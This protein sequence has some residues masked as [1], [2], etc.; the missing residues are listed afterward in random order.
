M[1]AIFLALTLT[2]VAGVAAA[3]TFQGKDT[4]GSQTSACDQ[5]VAKAKSNALQALNDMDIRT[6]DAR[7]AF[8]SPHCD[9]E[10]THHTIPGTFEG[11]QCLA[12]IEA[13]KV[14]K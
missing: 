2:G 9:C 7:L 6:G 13:S 4:G 1:K 3:E 5:A 8:G 10:K 11:Y 14:R 12:N